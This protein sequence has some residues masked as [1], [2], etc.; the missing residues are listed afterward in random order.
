MNSVLVAQNLKNYFSPSKLK[1]KIMILYILK[2]V[3]IKFQL[4]IKKAIERKCKRRDVTSIS[5][6]IT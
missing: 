2:K 3:I 6:K 4:I 1:K 5:L